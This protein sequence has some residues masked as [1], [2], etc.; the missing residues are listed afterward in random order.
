MFQPSARFTTQPV[1][2]SSA[3]MSRAQGAAQS[4]LGTSASSAPI[5]AMSQKQKPPNSSMVQWV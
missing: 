5:C 4:Q 1:R 3:V 2:N